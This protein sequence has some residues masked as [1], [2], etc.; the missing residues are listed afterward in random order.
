MTL[1]DST[2]HWEAWQKESHDLGIPAPH[3]VDRTLDGHGLL[4]GVQDGRLG[5]TALNDR[6]SVGILLGLRRGEGAQT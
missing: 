1:C 5:K 3:V 6:L 2:L 4:P